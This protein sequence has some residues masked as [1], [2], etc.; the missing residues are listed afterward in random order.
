MKFSGFGLAAVFCRWC[1]LLKFENIVS[2]YFEF[3]FHPM[4]WPLIFQLLWFSQPG[5]SSGLWRFFCS[6]ATLAVL[7]SVIMEQLERW[8]K[9]VSVRQW[10]GTAISRS[11]DSQ[12]LEVNQHFLRRECFFWFAVSPNNSAYQRV[13]SISFLFPKEWTEN[14][15]PL[16]PLDTLAVFSF[17]QRADWKSSYT[18]LFT[19]RYRGQVLFSTERVIPSYH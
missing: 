4:K 16:L 18:S 10:W 12:Y 2:P 6:H 7:G 17:V 3:R 13:Y 15:A 19:L 5:F 14:S 11:C 1:E 8:Q 9:Q